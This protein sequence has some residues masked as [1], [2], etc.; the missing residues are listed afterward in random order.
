M[1]E[2][3]GA[4]VRSFLAPDRASSGPDR[5]VRQLLLR[6]MGDGEKVERLIAFEQKRAPGISR[7]EAARRANERWSRDS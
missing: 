7:A 5:N 6:A 4:F 1:F 3:L 2:K